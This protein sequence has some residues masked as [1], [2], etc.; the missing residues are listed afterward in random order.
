MCKRG[1]PESLLDEIKVS[2]LVPNKRDFSTLTFVSFK[3]D[4][5]DVVAGIISKI[6]FWPP[7]C[8]LK[9][10]VQKPKSIKPIIDLASDE[11]TS[12]NFQMP[13]P[14]TRYVQRTYPNNH[15]T[16]DF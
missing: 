10:F 6:N 2:L 8:V 14:H 15:L 3:L 4:T 7:F 11:I 12:G 9:D 16:M 5:S 13:A 1:L